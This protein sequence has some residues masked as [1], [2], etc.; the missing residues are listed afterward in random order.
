M[1]RPQK[2]A[3]PSTMVM[4]RPWEMYTVVTKNP[5]KASTDSI[6]TTRNR[7]IREMLKHTGQ[8]IIFHTS[9]NSIVAIKPSTIHVL[10]VSALGNCSSRASTDAVWPNEY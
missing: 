7:G 4:I 5:A 6:A 2:T 9:A 8:A 3:R 1:S 10:A